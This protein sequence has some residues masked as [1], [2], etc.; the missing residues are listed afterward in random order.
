[1]YNGKN[2]M[3]PGGDEWII[4]GKLTVAEG[5]AIDGMPAATTN[6]VGGVKQAAAVLMS[7]RTVLP[8]RSG[9]RSNSRA[10]TWCSAIIQSLSTA[11]NP[12][13]VT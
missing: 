11:P 4:G 6:K 8:L 12:R 2:Y 1:M 10:S 3:A 7:I 13:P 9:I 5:G